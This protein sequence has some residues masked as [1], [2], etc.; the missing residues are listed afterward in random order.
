M[1]A[2]TVSPLERVIKKTAEDH[3]LA[4]CEVS[5]ITEFLSLAWGS[6]AAGSGG[7]GGTSICGL[8]SARAGSAGLAGFSQCVPKRINKPST[9]NPIIK[10]K[11][12]LRRGGLA[13][14]PTPGI[15]GMSI[16]KRSGEDCSVIVG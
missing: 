10:G 15:S 1:V 14:L 12:G 11:S 16:L 4:S 3:G 7:G 13:E 5:A 8:G 9:R 6:D 2:G